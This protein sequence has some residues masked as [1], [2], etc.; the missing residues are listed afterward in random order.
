[1]TFSSVLIFRDLRHSSAYDHSISL[2]VLVAC[3]YG[4]VVGGFLKRLFYGFVT[5][6]LA[7]PFTSPSPKCKRWF[8]VSFSAS[9]E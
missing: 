8:L 2:I 6:L 4:G 7:Q 5:G 3:N 1:V 9:E